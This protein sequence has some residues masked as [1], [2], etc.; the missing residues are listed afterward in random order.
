MSWAHRVPPMRMTATRE[1]SGP[2]RRVQRP[3][4]SSERESYLGRKG[5]P[6][7]TRET[8]IMLIRGRVGVEI[9][10]AHE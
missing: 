3:S 2:R 4:M 6:Y 1:L 7:W 5:G 8:D 9:D 10:R